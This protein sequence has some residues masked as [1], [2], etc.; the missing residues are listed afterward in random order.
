LQNFKTLLLLE[1]ALLMGTD[2]EWETGAAPAYPPESA[3]PASAAPAGG[4][5][6]EAGAANDDADMS[7]ETPCSPPPPPP[8]RSPSQGAEGAAPAP[9]PSPT[10]TVLRPHPA[11]P[12]PQMPT[13]LPL[14]TPQPAPAPQLLPPRL[15]PSSWTSRTSLPGRRKH[16]LVPHSTQVAVNNALNPLYAILLGAT[17]L[18]QIPWMA[19][20]AKGLHLVHFLRCLNYIQSDIRHPH[21]I[22]SWFR[23]KFIIDGPPRCRRRSSLFR[24]R[25]QAKELEL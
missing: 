13:M 10:K 12:T 21:C 14:Q 9:P 4:P 8:P 18:P 5:V 1:I 7:E 19:A 6:L 24:L 3:A 22:R 16:S 11:M 2:V 17:P 20:S 23:F 25:Q 15:M